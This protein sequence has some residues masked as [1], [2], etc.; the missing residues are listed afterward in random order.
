MNFLVSHWHCILPV[1]GVLAAIF[2][3]REKKEK[4]AGEHSGPPAL[5]D[6]ENKT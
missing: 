1:V 3:L 5:G 4:R 6:M 2:C